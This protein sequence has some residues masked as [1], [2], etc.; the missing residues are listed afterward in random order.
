MHA[1]FVA[2][3]LW[4]CAV[5]IPSPTVVL[6]N[7]VEMPAVAFAAQIWSRRQCEEYTGYALRAGF[8]F[9]WSS[10]L[11]GSQCQAG[12]RSAMEASG[13]PRAELFVAGT[14]DTKGCGDAAACYERTRALAEGQFALLGVET[15]DMLMLDY[16]SSRGCPAIMG[17][18][19][20]F[21]EIYAAGRVRTIAVSNFAAQHLGC[22]LANATA[23]VPAV[24]QLSFSIGDAGDPSVAASAKHGIA[25]QAWSPLR[26]GGA[27]RD[28]RCLAIAVAHHRS[29]AQVA[30]RWI[31]Q[32]GVAIATQSRSEAHLA[33]DLDLFDFALTDEEMEQLNGA[34]R[35]F[36]RPGM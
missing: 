32:R 12:Q 10:A 15:L 36:W 4:V 8:R 22:I 20:A 28:P 30:L 19:R 21:E 24:N 14:V 9:I 1:A 13:V 5:G 18:W 35:F 26:T 25:V 17:Q 29:P 33:A 2:I 31:L 27:L 16:P 7:G 34:G 23:V 6:N 3:S 11:V